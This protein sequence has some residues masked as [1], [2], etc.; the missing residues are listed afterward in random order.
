MGDT[1]DKLIQNSTAELLGV[2]RPTITKHPKNIIDK[3]KR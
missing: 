3:H 1:M 2:Q